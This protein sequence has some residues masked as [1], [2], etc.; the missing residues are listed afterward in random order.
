MG[1]DAVGT[2]MQ[3]I[4]GQ[5]AVLQRQV[6][7]RRHMGQQGVGHVAEPAQRRHLRLDRKGD[8]SM[9][10]MRVA[11]GLHA[12]ELEIADGQ[13][14]GGDIVIDAWGVERPVELEIGVDV[15]AGQALV[16]GV[17]PQQLGIDGEM[18]EAIGTQ[19]DGPFGRDGKGRR[20]QRGVDVDATL[21]A[22]RKGRIDRDLRLQQGDITDQQVRPRPAE[23]MEGAVLAGYLQRRQIVRA[24]I[25]RDVAQPVCPTAPAGDGGAERPVKMQQGN[26]DPALR[27]RDMAVE[28]EAVRRRNRVECQLDVVALVRRGQHLD[29]RPALEDMGRPGHTQGAG[30]GTGDASG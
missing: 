9:I 13:T 1:I 11:L 15:L 7:G 4:A 12:R 17:G 23:N 19:I 26:D 29:L 2:Q 3:I 6:A 30:V 25:G 20:T 22:Q 14:R 27:R 10:D 18:I 24:Q 16:E 28:R 8:D 21:V 5:L